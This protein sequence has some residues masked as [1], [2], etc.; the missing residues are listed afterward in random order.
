MDIDSFSVFFEQAITAIAL[1][2]IIAGFGGIIFVITSSPIYSESILDF[3]YAFVYAYM[4]VLGTLLY[5]YRNRILVRKQGIH[6]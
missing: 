1:V 6:N 4:L 5:L 3:A 2:F